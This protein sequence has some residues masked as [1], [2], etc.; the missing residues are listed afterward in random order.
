MKPF[1]DSVRRAFRYRK[2]VFLSVVCAVLGGVLW[3]AN[4]GTLYPVIEVVFR[5]ESIG[6]SVQR[7]IDE[8]ELHIEKLC[9]E[10]S[11]INSHL[12]DKS[13]DERITAGH[14]IE[15]RLMAERR[16]LDNWKRIQPFADQYLP[17][18][19]ISTLLMVLGMLLAST[20]LKGV[21]QIANEVLVAYVT[22]RTMFDLRKQFYRR[23]LR[24]D[25]A[26]FSEER[27]SRLMSRFTHDLTRVGEGI[28]VIFSR[29]LQEP[30]KIVVC[31]AGAAF[32]CWRLLLVSLICAPV[33]Y[34]VIRQISRLARQNADTEMS[35][36]AD[37]YA[38]LAE[39][40][41]G[42]KI[43]LAF[44]RTQHERKKFHV[45]AKQLFQR[46]MRAAA[47][48]SFV[49]PATELV[50]MLVIAVAI[51]LGASLVLNRQTEVFGITLSTQPL[52]ATTLLLF[53]AFLLGASGPIKKLS[54]ISIQLSRTASAAARIDKLMDREPTIRQI[55]DPVLFPKI[56]RR[57]T[58]HD[59]KFRY[60]RGENILKKI[61]LTIEAGQNI[62]IVGPNG[63][64][65][66]TLV[67]LL[68]RFYDTKN[69]SITINGID[70]RRFRVQD[71]RSQIS[72]APQECMLFDESVYDNIR[73]SLRNATHEDVIQAAKQAG[74]H[75]FIM[76]SLPDGYET[77][78]GESGCILSGG[79]RQRLALARAC[80]R[81]APIW[82]LDET[83]SNIDADA[84]DE[85]Y[86]LL[87]TQLRHR[88]AII[89]THRAADLFLADQIVVMKAGRISDAGTHSELL[90]RS[91]YYQRLHQSG[92][93]SQSLQVS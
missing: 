18:N 38:H 64:G 11:Q 66:S 68:A 39:S 85:F 19:P 80:L 4:I 46:R 23:T 10:V 12:Q 49:K 90:L 86:G 65:K 69:G 55:E 3:G 30:A 1:F 47:Y 24:L 7:H 15:S 70:I 37:M 60:R 74:A 59:V 32:I 8:C 50:S 14:G 57:I 79:Q 52:D 26:T 31:L 62:A 43:V 2:H 77:V 56:I 78:I 61:H 29:S 5:G 41:R 71:L 93:N 87:S 82:I 40:F 34:L 83:T 25:L 67:N 73:Y 17:G 75:E 76:S 63:C 33:G 48:R 22:Q 35:A 89:I 88:T 36:M 53:Y 16:S 20:L 51:M 27:S 72:I 45:L 58:F 13:D 84:I 44:G 21:F 92:L 54:E 81:N 9:G 6:Q 91:R 28:Q 42:I